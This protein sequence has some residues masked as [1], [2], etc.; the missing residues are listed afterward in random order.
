MCVCVL[1]ASSFPYNLG[2]YGMAMNGQE[3]FYAIHKGES[4]KSWSSIIDLNLTMCVYKYIQMNTL[5]IWLLYD[6]YACINIFTY[7]YSI[8]IHI[9]ISSMLTPWVWYSWRTAQHNVALVITGRNHDCWPWAEPNSILN[10]ALKISGLYI[11]PTYG[12]AI[13]TNIV[14]LHLNHLK[15]CHNC[16]ESS[17]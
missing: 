13:N 8:H 5:Y 15:I 7:I 2:E 3:N 4:K 12:Y 14:K 16:K 11:L 1:D 10:L 9:H 17:K 6:I